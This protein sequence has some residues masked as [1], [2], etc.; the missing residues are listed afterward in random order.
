M[1]ENIRVAVRVRPFNER[2]RKRGAKLVIAMNGQT[3]YIVNPDQPKEKPRP[4][5]FDFSYWSHDGF[6]TEENGYCRAK[7][8]HY[9]DQ[10]TS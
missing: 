10:V 2:E 6:V 8:P 9:V 5:T 7:V 4:Y 3:T 1:S